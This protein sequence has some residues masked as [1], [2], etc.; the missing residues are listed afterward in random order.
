MTWRKRAAALGSALPDPIKSEAA[1]S[2]AAPV[3]VEN[4]TAPGQT[5]PRGMAPRTTYSR[6]NTGG[7]PT[8][9]VG[10]EQKATPPRGM[11][12]LPQKVAHRRISMGSM[13]TRPLLQD[14][15]K[16]AM[17]A[18]V[19]K[20]S[21]VDEAARQLGQPQE[22]TAA[23]APK[24]SNHIPSEV[25]VKYA[26]ALEYMAK[27]SADPGSAGVASPGVG[28]GQGAGQ[29]MEVLEAT[30]EDPPI[31]P[32]AQGQATSKNVPPKDP[33][34]RSFPDNKGPA[35]VMDDNLEMQ[36]PEQPVDPMNNEKASNEG[37]KE[38]AALFRKNAAALGLKKQA[39]SMTPEGHEYDAA[40][41]DAAK[42][43]ALQQM[44]TMQQHGIV[45]YGQGGEGG[46][47]IPNI[48]KSLMYQLTTPA[49]TGPE[50]HPMLAARMAHAKAEAHKQGKN[51]WNPF[52]G[53]GTP[54]PEE[55]GGTPGVFGT[56]GGVKK[57]SAAKALFAKNAAAL[58]LKKVAEDAINPAQ[59]SAGAA[60]AQGAEAPQG[61]S[62]SEE[63]PIPAEPSDVNSQKR[64]IGT[65][66]AAINYTK[67][68]AKAD[69]KRDLGQLITEPALSASTDK[70]L[71]IAFDNTN[72]AGAKIAS[73]KKTPSPAAR[74]TKTAAAH[75]LLLKMAEEACADPKAKK[76]KNSQAQMGVTP[77]PAQP[78][79]PLGQAGQGRHM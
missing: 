44:Q 73:A 71:D 43:H 38:S 42:Q 51:V 62:A 5:G 29:V 33:P 66:D 17:D 32:G 65:N 54:I 2:P 12:F 52:K 37:L 23:A 48:G 56:L 14:L 39:L 8:P 13:M 67:R 61:V 45:G 68:Q 40:M 58:G 18:T 6:V 21:I 41:S 78:A 28:P 30:S 11:E 47:F 27:Q 20:V 46:A 70:T 7:S 19:S 26:E 69:P 4:K 25:C 3:A 72:A 15:V 36:H 74:L 55:E 75:A 64:L 59:I 22:K 35:N 53:L 34:M 9:Q 79:P 31:Q 49:G 1:A 77:M 76:E 60:S 63:G 16:Q 50:T 57:E 24:P 10:G